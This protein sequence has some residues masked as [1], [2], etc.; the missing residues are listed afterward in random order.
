METE[1]AMAIWKPL[2][3]PRSQSKGSGFTSTGTLPASESTWDERLTAAAVNNWVRTG[4]SSL[5]DNPKLPAS[6]S[7]LDTVQDDNEALDICEVRKQAAA[8]AYNV[9]R[10]TLIYAWLRIRATVGSARKIVCCTAYRW[11]LFGRA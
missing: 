8:T 7:N 10:K 6:G 4:F 1:L 2:Q 5:I 9:D 3:M 11:T